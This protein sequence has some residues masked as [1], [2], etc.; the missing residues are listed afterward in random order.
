GELNRIT[1]RKRVRRNPSLIAAQ[2]LR[3]KNQFVENLTIKDDANCELQTANSSS[4]LPLL[5]QHIEITV[6]LHGNDLIG[7]GKL[8]G[9][10]QQVFPFFIGGVIIKIIH[11]SQEMHFPVLGFQV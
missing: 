9:K 8:D 4:R 11:G 3:E 10:L 1:E 7:P 2:Q 6:F 5:K